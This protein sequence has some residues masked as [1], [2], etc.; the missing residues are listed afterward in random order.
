MMPSMSDERTDSSSPTALV[1][2]WYPVHDESSG[3]RRRI[4][5][6]LRALAPNVRFLQPPT[7]H[8]D[9]PGAAIPVDFGNPK[10]YINWGMFNLYWPSNRRLVRRL[11]VQWRPSVIVSASIWCHSAFAGLGIPR[12]FDAQNADARTIADRYGPRHPVTRIVARIERRVLRESEI[13]FCCS[14]IDAASFRSDYG[15][16][17]GKIVVVP[18]GVTIPDTPAA[19]SPEAAALRARDAGKTVLYFMGKTDYAPNADAMRWIARHLLP[20]LERRAPGRFVCWISGGGP[21]LPP[22]AEHPSLR[23]LGRVPSVA[24]WLAAADITL[25]PVES[26]GGTR[27]KILEFLGAGKPLV[28]T[29]KAAEGIDLVP[30]VE[31]DIVPLEDMPAA[32]LSLAADPARAAALGTAGRAKMRAAYT[33]ESIRV[34]WRS[35]LS[36]Y[37]I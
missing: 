8:P 9:F 4:S 6:L 28:A 25:A 27:L 16:P 35:A 19:P 15:I 32:I 3:G 30:G 29:P 1:V 37:G 26:G 12:V 22:G 18:N 13:V 5:E 11:A 17:P 24:P 7:A 2:S 14:D 23:W 21:G 36:R 20:E 31:A 34:R 10:L 33:W